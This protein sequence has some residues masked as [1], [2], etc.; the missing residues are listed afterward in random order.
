[1]APTPGRMEGRT[2]W[3]AA[4][5]AADNSGDMRSERLKQK[6]TLKTLAK[7]VQNAVAILMRIRVMEHE[8]TSSLIFCGGQTLQAVVFSQPAETRRR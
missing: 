2:R 1:M 7:P 4:S 3:W 8:A 6:D 5:N